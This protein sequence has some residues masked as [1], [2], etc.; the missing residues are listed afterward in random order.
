MA[1]DGQFSFVKRAEDGK[2]HTYPEFYHFHSG[3]HTIRGDESRTEVLNHSKLE[4]KKKKKDPKASEDQY[5]CACNEFN[6]L[7]QQLDQHQDEVW[8]RENNANLVLEQC[9]RTDI[10]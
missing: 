8:W 3:G 1:L 6:T 5:K 2:W 10:R 7:A 9:T 4:A